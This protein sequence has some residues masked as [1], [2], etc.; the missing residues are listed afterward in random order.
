MARDGEKRGPKSKRTAQD[1][2][3]DNE[4]GT[5]WLLAYVVGASMDGF[6][7]RVGLTRDGGA[8]ALGVYMGEQYG[9]EYI[10]PDEDLAVALREIGLAWGLRPAFFDT[11][12]NRWIIQP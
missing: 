8:L 7:L 9:T 11:T 5:D 2:S 4:E 6:A 10:R 3:F 1:Y 12:A